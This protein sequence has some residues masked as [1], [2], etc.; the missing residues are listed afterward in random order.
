MTQKALCKFS[1]ELLKESSTTLHKTLLLLTLLYS[2]YGGILFVGGWFL[3]VYFSFA[4][5]VLVWC[6][7]RLA[8]RVLLAFISARGRC[9]VIEQ[10]LNAISLP[11]GFHRKTVKSL[12]RLYVLRG[13]VRFLFRLLFLAAVL[14]GAVLLYAASDRQEG[15]YFMLGA[16]Q[17][18]PVLIALAVFRFR[19]ETAFCAAETVS[20]RCPE[21]SSF[22]S[23]AQGFRIMKGQYVFAAMSVLRRGLLVI[24]PVTQPY[25]AFTA[26]VFFAARQLEY[27]NSN[28]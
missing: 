9:R 4:E 26:A 7:V 17:F 8:L 10:S 20:V 1:S 24:L 16:A 11:Y 25:F 2:V 3:C 12:R 28:S 21:K 19:M 23:A 22:K 14:A 6:A 5:G 18:V 15:A 13:T 27:D